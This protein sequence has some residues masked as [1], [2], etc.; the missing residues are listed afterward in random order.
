MK[1]SIL[2]ISLL[3]LITGSINLSSQVLDSPK[4][5]G[6]YDKIHNVNRKPIP[7]AFVREADVFWSKRIWRV[8]D[9]KEKMNQP[10]YF[11]IEPQ[12]GRK[13]FMTIIFDALKE[14]TIIAYEAGQYNDEFLA[15]ISPVQLLSSLTRVDSIRLQRSYPPYDW[16]DTIKVKE[17][18]TSDVTRIR[19]KEDWFFD[20]QRSVMESRIIGICPI[21]EQFNDEDQ[22]FKGYLP[23][24]WIYFPDLRPILAKNEV[25]NRFNDGLRLSY[26]DVFMKRMFSSYIYKES[27]VYDRKIVEYTKGVDQI[28]ESE[29]IKNEINNYE[30]ELWEY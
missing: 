15:P 23:L 13:S 27:N 6:I 17:F 18:R 16:Y 12:N 7:Y 22:S 11:P 8:I 30:R 2:I 3:F 14:G 21:I 25:F 10:F 20:K 29:R 1:K 26:D 28:F 24:F 9:F 5:D 19:I 4:R